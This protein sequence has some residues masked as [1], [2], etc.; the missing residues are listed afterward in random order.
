MK[1]F[2]Q[3]IRSLLTQKSDEQTTTTHV[4]TQTLQKPLK[5]NNSSAIRH[6]EQK[7]I[8]FQRFQENKPLKTSSEQWKRYGNS[9][10]TTNEQNKVITATKQFAKPDELRG[11]CQICNDAEK[12]LF[13]CALTGAQVCKKCLKIHPHPDHPIPLSPN[14]HKQLL[15]QWDEW[16]LKDYIEKKNNSYAA[17]KLFPFYQKA[18]QA[19]NRQ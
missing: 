17:H 13:I 19:W 15:K 8:Q 6:A 5:E 16:A 7:Q 11:L 2:I 4:R 12:H 9:F 14:A 10:K 18:I 1:K 3:K